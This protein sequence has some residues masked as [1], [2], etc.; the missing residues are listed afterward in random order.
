MRSARAELE[1]VC[2]DVFKALN[3]S[4]TRTHAKW[5][6]S[7]FD[8]RSY[9]GAARGRARFIPVQR[10]A[11]SAAAAARYLATR[12]RG[13]GERR[14]GRSARGRPR[15][16]GTEQRRRARF[17]PLFLGSMVLE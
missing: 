3:A 9:S 13:P 2:A 6:K 8:P 11:M 7:P 4:A 12:S 1:S 15:G 17:R 16:V 5:S 14:D 10:G